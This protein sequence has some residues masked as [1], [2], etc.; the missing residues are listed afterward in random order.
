MAQFELTAACDP[1][2][3]PDFL[4]EEVR[5]GH[6]SN[7]YYLLQSWSLA[8][9]SVPFRLGDLRNEAV[10][11]AGTDVLLKAL[12]G[13]LWSTLFPTTP[14]G[15]T[16]LPRQSVLVLLHALERL[17]ARFEGVEETK[18]AAAASYAVISEA[19]KKRR[20]SGQ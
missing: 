3:L 10:A 19:S 17:K 4:P 12:L 5:L 15:K 18:L 6:C 16:V 20:A 2:K 11:K 7:L 13:P 1:T 14:S 8:G 9:G